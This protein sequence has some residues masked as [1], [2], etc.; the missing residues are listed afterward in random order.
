MYYTNDSIDTELIDIIFNMININKKNRI[1]FKNITI[2]FNKYN[3]TNKIS[4]EKNNDEI[5][6]FDEIS[7]N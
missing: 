6:I 1:S 5:F 4:T 2:F 7:F 3:K